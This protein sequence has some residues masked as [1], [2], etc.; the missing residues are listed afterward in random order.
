[1]EHFLEAFCLHHSTIPLV[2]STVENLP[3]QH[4]CYSFQQIL[5]KPLVLPPIICGME[6][7]G[8]VI[9]GEKERSHKFLSFLDSYDHYRS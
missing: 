9:P 3:Q 1:M 6:C 8:L 7:Q 2:F 4:Q 5:A